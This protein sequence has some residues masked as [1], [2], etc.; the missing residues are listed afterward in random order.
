MPVN[1]CKLDILWNPCEK[2]KAPILGLFS[3]IRAYQALAFH[4][5]TFATGIFM[6]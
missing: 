3:G 1:A 4:C 5:Q 2:Q 6:L